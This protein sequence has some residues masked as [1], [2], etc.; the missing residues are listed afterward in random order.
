MS[1]RR[2]STPL[3]LLGLVSSL[4]LVL[5]GCG[6]PGGSD[7]SG[8]E[9]SAVPRVRHLT[10]Q[11]TRSAEGIST[12][13]TQGLGSAQVRQVQPGDPAFIQRLDI[14]VQTP[15]GADLL[16]PQA[17]PLG[18]GDQETVTLDVLL[19]DPLPAEFQILV[20][21]FNN[22]N[23]QQT[24][25]FL[26]QVRIQRG[27]DSASL[28]LV[29]NPDPTTLIP[30]LATP[31][32]LQQMVFAF[33]NGAIFGVG[34]VGTPVTLTT[35][36]FQ[37]QTGS[38]TLAAGSGTASGQVTISSCVFVVTVST[39]AAGRG[40]QVGD[41][42]TFDPC[43]VDAVDGRMTATNPSLGIS[44]TS[45]APVPAST[46][47][48]APLVLTVARAGTGSGTVTSSPLGIT[49]GPTCTATFNESTPVDLTA[50]PAPGSFFTGWSDDGAICGSANPCRVT[51]S[52]ALT[53]TAKFEATV[54]SFPLTVVKAGTGSGTVTSSP[55]GIDCGSTCSVSFPKGTGVTLTATAATGSTFTGWSG[56]GCGGTG[57]CT[58][59]MDQARAVTADFSAAVGN[60]PPAPTAPPISIDPNTSGTSQ[61][62]PN[63]PDAGQ[64]FTFDITTLPTHGMANVDT[65]GLVTYTPTTDFT[66]SDSLV[67]TVTDNGTP[68]LSG[69][70]T[71]SILVGSLRTISAAPVG[72]SVL[73]LAPLGQV[74]SV[75][76]STASI[77]LRLVDSPVLVDTPVSI[78]STASTV[79]RVDGTVTLPAGAQG[80]LVVLTT[81]NAGEAVLT[82]QAGATRQQLT[83]IVGVPQ[84][85]RVPPVLAAPVG[86]SVLSL[87]P[88]GQVV[89]LPDS[90]ASIF[91]HLVDSPVGVDTPVSITSTDPTVVTVT[92]PVIIPAG[93]QGAL[94][95]LT[96]G[97]AGEAVLTFQA[98]A[99]RQ[100][101][102]IIVGAPQAGRVPPVQAPI[103]GVDV[104]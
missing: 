92:G 51:M 59:I 96:T 74:V 28:T 43:Q 33:P 36:R 82:F 7:G 18:P 12:A 103:V 32:T 54:S 55:A 91:L 61:V 22:F 56:E 46:V 69:T 93:A 8:G 25:I 60:R 66:G 64:S 62:T 72:L 89:T 1:Q 20:S 24:K 86:L 50:T 15:Q 27:Q 34:L 52:Q 9:G 63:D 90:M 71:I 65:M 47:P 19:P 3:Y 40:P 85:G 70:V 42:I 95:L 77:F 68:P 31:T 81:G 16:A 78:T 14:Q 99:T 57:T 44:A 38:F 98:G 102:T 101:L 37:G 58:V 73:S 80:V 6:G 100:Q 5:V 21:A 87:A 26:G 11:L 35:G 76:N 53:V 94:V 97:S 29:R 45:E 41:R 88:L 83:I 49:C 23:N 84:A 30:V 75:P 17:F 104:E 67:V 13:R 79:A 4:W 2:Y 10:L 39:F 48:T